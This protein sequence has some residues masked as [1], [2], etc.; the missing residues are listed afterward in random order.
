MLESCLKY[1]FLGLHGKAVAAW[2]DGD[3]KCHGVASVRA[4]GAILTHN[5]AMKRILIVGCGDIAQRVAALLRGHCRL[6]GLVRS[7]ARFDELRAAGIV[8][9]SGDLDDVRSLH[10]LAGLAHIVLHFAPPPSEGKIDLRTRNLLATLSRGALPQRLVYI[11]TS[12]VYG[13]CAGAHVAETH[14]L[15][16]QNARARLRVSAENQ[17]RNWAKHNGVNASILRVPGIYAADRLPLERLRAGSPAI[18]ASEDSYTNHIHAGDLARIILAAIR[19]GKSNRVYH[20]SDDSGL[21][22]GEYFDCVADALGLPRPPRISRTEAQR[23]LPP[24]MLSFMNESRRLGNARMKKE[25]KVVLRYPTV[26]D[27]LATLKK[28]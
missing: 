11:S 28:F 15:N 20:T 26:A 21:T 3:L 23:V 10:R 7:A 22:M 25:L 12:G 13:D 17:I 16:A 14:P 8:P 9:I 19:K 2:F 24:M 4:K 5:C 6:F 27:F 1:G 18:A